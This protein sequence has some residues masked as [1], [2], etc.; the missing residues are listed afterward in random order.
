[1]EMKEKKLRNSSVELLRILCV[2][3]IIAQHYVHHGGY[4]DVFFTATSPNVIYLKTIRMFGYSACTVFAL[5]TGYYMIDADTEHHYYR[6]IFDLALMSLIYSLLSGAILIGGGF[7]SYSL[8]ELFQMFF[9]YF[10]GN[11][12]VVFYIVILFLAPYLNKALKSLGQK[13]YQKLTV[14]LFVLFIVIQ[15]VFGNIYKT[16]DLDFMLNAY[17]F[18][19]YYKLYHV[20]W[21]I[22]DIDKTIW[23]FVLC[24]IITVFSVFVMDFLGLKTGI[25]QFIKYDYLLMSSRNIVAFIMS[26]SI[27]IYAVNKE[28]YN[29]FINILASSVLGVYLI[30]DGPL[31]IIIWEYVY[32]NSMYATTPYIHCLIKI[33]SVFLACALIDL[34]RQK[35]IGKVMPK[36]YDKIGSRFEW[37]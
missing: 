20:N 2:L 29:N 12:Y 16:G 19:A 7:K 25:S 22:K 37:F 4:D 36:L 27:F 34:L 24:F 30:H 17:I 26:V 14:T 18:G 5:I 35:T 15:N 28:F 11:W 10:Y 33:P 31:K 9:P 13:D 32:P 6:K 8:I 23:I 3:G 21:L 1:M